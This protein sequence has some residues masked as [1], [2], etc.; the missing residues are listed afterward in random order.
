MEIKT[1]EVN[2]VLIIPLRAVKDKNGVNSVE[3]LLAEKPKSVDVSLGLKGDDGLVE[4]KSGLKEGDKVI[5]FVRNN[6]K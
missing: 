5:T 1:A 4:V 3:V 2:D 6:N